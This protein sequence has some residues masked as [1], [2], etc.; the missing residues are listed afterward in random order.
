MAPSPREYSPDLGFYNQIPGRELGPG[1]VQGS[2]PGLST[3]NLETLD[4]SAA[5]L[6]LD[7][8]RMESMENKLFNLIRTNPRTSTKLLVGL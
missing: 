4:A 3:K 6:C 2:P 5:L 1:T 8:S 7:S